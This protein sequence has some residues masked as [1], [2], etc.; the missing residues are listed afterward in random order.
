MLKRYSLLLFIFLFVACQQPTKQTPPSQEESKA[1]KL[2]DPQ[3]E[4]AAEKI[5][6]EFDTSRE[7]FI[8]KDDYY[9]LKNLGSN[10]KLSDFKDFVTAQP[11]MNNEDKEKLLKSIQ[12]FKDSYRISHGSA[13]TTNSFIVDVFE[14]PYAYSL[15]TREQKEKLIDFILEFSKAS[16]QDEKY[17]L[18]SIEKSND[19]SENTGL[20]QSN[21][22]RQKKY[23]SKNQKLKQFYFAHK[24]EIDSNSSLRNSFTRR[25]AIETK[26]NFL[27][28]ERFFIREKRTLFNILLR[29][30]EEGTNA[31]LDEETL[32]YIKDYQ[33]VVDYQLS[34]YGWI[35]GSYRG[36]RFGYFSYP[37]KDFE[38]ITDPNSAESYSTVAELLVYLSRNVARNRGAFDFSKFHLLTM[39]YSNETAR[40]N[41]SLVDLVQRFK[42]SKDKEK[43]Q[44]PQILAAYLLTEFKT[45]DLIKPTPKDIRIDMNKKWLDLENRH[46]RFLESNELQHLELL[47]QIRNTDVTF[48]LR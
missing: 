2:V 45:E 37:V 36:K 20:R 48:D 6:N 25:L 24:Q 9:P 30:E 32:N 34:K 41:Q 19:E 43:Q 27:C 31:N 12:L 23:Q 11:K 33:E 21:D 40:N 17:I 10:K 39:T 4:L 29:P 28:S 7:Y 18:T 8:G 42:A 13:I 16:P 5:I 38:V 26:A 3:F 46:L 22:F 15:N 14:N 35:S 44:A 47:E 1:Y